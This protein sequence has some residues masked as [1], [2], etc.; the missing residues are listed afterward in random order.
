MSLN[1]FGQKKKFA[2]IIKYWFL[3]Q[4][5][6]QI[7]SFDPNVHCLKILWLIIGPLCTISQYFEFKKKKWQKISEN[8]NFWLFLPFFFFKFKILWYCIQSS[9]NHKIHR[10]CTLGS[11]LKICQRNCHKNQHLFI[12]DDF[13]KNF[14]FWPNLEFYLWGFKIVG[15][16]QTQKKTIFIK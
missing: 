16:R 8:C 9:D 12:F 10:Q 3:W 7:F 13:G 6:W 5:L 1:K 2:K 11:K 4:F 14:D 15:N